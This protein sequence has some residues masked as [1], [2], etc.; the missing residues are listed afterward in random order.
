MIMLNE[1][2]DL[3]KVLNDEG[4]DVDEWSSDYHP[5]PKVTRQSPCLRIWLYDDGSVYKIENLRAD[6]VSEIRKYGSKQGTFPAFNIK[7][8]Y[9]TTDID[10]AAALK[11]YKAGLTE[12]DIEKIESWATEDNWNGKPIRHIKQNMVNCPDKLLHIL[13]ME[14][15]TDKNIIVKLAELSLKAYG[16]NGSKFHASLENCALEMLRNKE[17]I[18]IAL[19]LLF[20][21]GSDDKERDKDIG[22]NISIILD[23]RDWRS[24]NYPVANEHTTIQLNKLLLESRATNDDISDSDVPDAFGTVF[25]NPNEP[26]PSVNVGSLGEVILRSMY[27]GQPCQERYCTF[28]CDSYPISSENR[29][30]AASA[31]SWINEPSNEHVTWETVD[32]KE[33]VFVYPS[34]L[35]EIPLKYASM[36]SS[37]DDITAQARRRFETVAKE[38]SRAFSGLSVRQKNCNVQIF[39]IRKIDK[40]RSKVLYSRNVTPEQ[41][42]QSANLWMSGCRNVPMLVIGELSMPFPLTVADTLNAA[43]KQDGNRRDGNKRPIKHMKY[44]QGMDLLFGTLPQSEIDDLLHY[45]LENALGL[46]KYLGD[47]LH[48]GK[49]S[50]DKTANK[51]LEGQLAA[52]RKT[53]S[54]FG[55]LLFK[56]NIR[57]ENYMEGLAFQIGQF[58]HA[59][60][61]LHVLYCKVKRNGDI[62]PQLAGSALL[63]TAGEMPY[64]ALSLLSARMNPY[65]SWAKKYQFSNTKESWRARWLLGLL[66]KTSDCIIPQMDEAVRFGD[67]EKA[68]LFIGYMASFPKAQKASSMVDEGNEIGGNQNE[69]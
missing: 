67:F 13:H 23:V 7:P 59:S 65:I 5:L 40:A 26:M 4:I 19:M 50:V 64:Q 8:L 44:Y 55:L 68:E 49:T 18:S 16:E 3:A 43:W 48:R 46:V 10:A 45:L 57:K 21:E 30:L 63:A 14:G 38:F 27:K 12:L 36:L 34:I 35:P 32:T 52:A 61:E 33:R 54:V 69:Q 60:D 47:L 2:H 25:D 15:Q 62:P 41:I 53:Y 29:S 28:D 17:D 37:A 6:Q 51:K 31:L 66:Q 58:L 42:I 24:Y 11:Q 20:H 56:S 39:I 9:R 1:L 22:D